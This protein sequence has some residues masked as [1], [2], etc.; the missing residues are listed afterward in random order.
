M[1]AQYHIA[2]LESYGDESRWSIS[3][4]RVFYLTRDKGH[5]TVAAVCVTS[6]VATGTCCWRKMAYQVI[7]LM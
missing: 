5:A 6:D 1:G 3:I 2:E 7:C 4:A